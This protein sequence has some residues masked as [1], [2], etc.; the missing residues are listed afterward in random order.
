MVKVV[1]EIHI[2]NDEQFEVLIKSPVELMS[3]QSSRMVEVGDASV[4]CIPCDVDVRLASSPCDG[5]RWKGR[6]DLMHP[7]PCIF[8]TD[9]APFHYKREDSFRLKVLQFEYMRLKDMR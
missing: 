8:A 3:A 1:S 7:G 2:S 4:L 5:I 6:W 9:S